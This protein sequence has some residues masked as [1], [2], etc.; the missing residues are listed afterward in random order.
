MVGGAGMT[1]KR[2]IT[3]SGPRFFWQAAECEIHRI[4]YVGAAAASVPTRWYCQT[5]ALKGD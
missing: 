4:S 3:E 5:V 2:P 1:L